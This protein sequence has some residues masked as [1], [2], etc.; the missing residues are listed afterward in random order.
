MRITACEVLYSAKNSELG[1]SNPSTADFTASFRVEKSYAYKISDSFLI[2]TTMD[3]KKAAAADENLLPNKLVRNLI[4]YKIVHYTS[5][6]KTV[7]AGNDDM[8]KDYLR[9]GNECSEMFIF[10]RYGDGRTIVIYD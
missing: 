6:K 9:M 8:L 10:D 2:T 3:L 7:S 5:E 4:G 1:T